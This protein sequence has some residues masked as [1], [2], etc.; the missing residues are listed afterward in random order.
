[1]PRYSRLIFTTY[2]LFTFA[3]LILSSQLN[4]NNS[5]QLFLFTVNALITCFFY[6]VIKIK[7]HTPNNVIFWLSLLSNLILLIILHVLTGYWTEIPKI[8]ILTLGYP[9]FAFSITSVF[10]FYRLIQEHLANR[11]IVAT[12][13]SNGTMTVDGAAI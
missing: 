6:A 3:L 12:L 11:P 7:L 4:N 1:M 8:G 10:L 9:H 2:L 5:I 13:H